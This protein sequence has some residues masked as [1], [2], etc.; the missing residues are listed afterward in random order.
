M[1]NKKIKNYIDVLFSDIP[2]TNKAVELR[3]ELLANMNERFEDYIAEGK[4]E[5]Q[6][7]SLVISNLGDIDHLIEEV[8]PSETFK[9]Q[10]LYYR[11][12]NAIGTAVAVMLYILG[13]AIVVAT[14]MM[15][16]TAVII[17]TV[18]LLVLAAVATG[19]LIYINMSTP[20]EYKVVDEE[21]KQNLELYKTKKGKYLKEIE[22][23]IWLIVTC[24]FFVS[25]FVFNYW[26]TA[27]II[28][29]LTGILLEIIKTLIKIGGKDEE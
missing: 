23:L 3:E 25:M 17:G 28:F 9:K 1:M 2:K 22:S 4:S 11:K 8:M 21:E 16:N 10:A 15:I 18:I 5:N 24:I 7:Y 13:A 20:T 27:W 6:A 12:R 26:G 14:S 29:P 19:L